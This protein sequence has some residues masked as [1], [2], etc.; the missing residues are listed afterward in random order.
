MAHKLTKRETIQVIAALRYW[1]RAAESGLTHPK[2]HPMVKARLRGVLPMTND[3][4]ETL[5]GKLDGSW[6]SRGLRT[7]D[8]ARYL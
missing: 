8:P 7:W 1:G 3:E 2:E 4:I 5:I 6:G